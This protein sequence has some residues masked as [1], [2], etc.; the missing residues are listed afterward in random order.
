MGKVV[1]LRKLDDFIWATL[2]GW[3]KLP[4]LGN[5]MGALESL[6]LERKAGR[7]KTED[8]PAKIQE[9]R[10]K[11]KDEE[12][13]LNL[14]KF[15]A[16]QA[17]EDYPY[18]FSLVTVRLWAM[19]ESAAREVLVEASKTPL[20]LPNPAALEKLKA[21]IAP[22]VGANLEV[23]AELVADIIWQDV[24]GTFT[25]LGRTEAALVR[26]GLGG[27]PHAVIKEILLELSEV[28]HCVVHRGALADR[29]LLENCPWLAGKPGD[30]LPATL[31]RFWLYRTATYWYVMDLARR[32]S[33]WRKVQPIVQM[34]D[35]LEIVVL[36]ELIPNWNQDKRLALKAPDAS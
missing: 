27:P 24:K 29:R 18:L 19:V 5:L 22:F 32:W 6:A 13:A 25:G 35:E 7:L 14:Y 9:L 12:E 16:R 15:A 26:L 20:E 2:K 17:K 30:F 28:R 23:Q 4:V 3:G 8:I 1:E 36:E 31:G 33:R 34:A 11:L 21:P 10:A